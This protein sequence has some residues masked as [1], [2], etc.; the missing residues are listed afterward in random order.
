MLFFLGIGVFIIAASRIFLI[1][2][3]SKMYS[4][5]ILNPVFDKL[6]PVYR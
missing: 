6:C 2:Y 5:E 4:V 3:L 1:I